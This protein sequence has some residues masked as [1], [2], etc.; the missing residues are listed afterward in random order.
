MASKKNRNTKSARQALRARRERRNKGSLLGIDD[1]VRRFSGGPGGTNPEGDPNVST[2]WVWNAT[3]GNYGRWNGTIMQWFPPGQGGAPANPP[4]GGV[5]TSDADTNT[6]ENRPRIGDTRVNDNGVAE[7]FTSEG[8]VPSSEEEEEEE[9]EEDDSGKNETGPKEGD[10]REANGIKYIYT[11][12][13]WVAQGVPE[14][15]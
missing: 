10:I 4:T 7:I 2:E 6:G 8:W 9:E 5:A 14:E 12:G 1:R 11:S 13:V 15:G 3:T